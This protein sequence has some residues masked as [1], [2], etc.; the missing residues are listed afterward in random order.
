MAADEVLVLEASE[1]VVTEA[2]VGARL[3]DIAKGRGIQGPPPLDLVRKVTIAM[4]QSK[5]MERD[6]L[7]KGLDKDPVV[8]AALDQA[9]RDVLKAYLMRSL[10]ED[11]EVPD[12]SAAARDYYDTHLKEFTA[13]PRIQVSHILLRLDCDCLTCDCLAQRDEKAA[14]A[15]EVLDRLAKGE[16]FTQLAMELSEDKGSASLGGS[17]KQWTTFEEL[18]LH[19][20]KAAFALEKGKTSDIVQTRFGFHIIRLD[21]R[22]EEK[23]IPFEEVKANLVDK[24]KKDYLTKEKAKIAQ[25]YEDKAAT[26]TWNEAALE[27]LANETGQKETQGPATPAEPK[28]NP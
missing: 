14:K 23:Q 21:D 17:L 5:V 12:Q 13:P 20:A 2:E 9:R 27:R 8:A 4:F 24:L 16:N 28:G 25:F 18:D 10:E 26:G 1:G 3:G 22:V 7:A 15:K 6:A 11:I 19:F